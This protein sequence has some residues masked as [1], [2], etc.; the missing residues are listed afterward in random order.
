[1]KNLG[2]S[3]WERA[4]TFRPE[5]SKKDLILYDSK[6]LTTHAVCVGMTGSGKTGLCMALVEEAAI[7]GIP[8]IVID[9]KGD[10]GN[11]MLTF[12][13]LAPE[14]FRPWVDEGEAVRSGMTGDQFARKVSDLWRS[15]LSEWGQG[16]ERIARLRE[17]A[18]FAIYTPG[19]ASGLQIN[20]L[21]SFD[22]PPPHSSPMGMPSR[23]GSRVPWKDFS[24]FWES[25][26]TRFRVGN[27]FFFQTYSPMPG[28]GKRGLDL[29]NSFDPYRNHPSTTWGSSTWSLSLMRPPGSNWPCGSTTCSHPRAFQHGS[30]VNPSA[31]KASFTRRR[32]GPRS[33][34][35]PSPISPTLNECSSSRF[36]SMRSFRGCAANRAPQ[37][38]VP[39]FIWMKSSDIS[40]LRPIPPPNGPC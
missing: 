6:D 22:P 14:D 26:P 3:T 13:T 29:Q 35:S 39:S 7:D 9:P 32:D 21:R 10:L 28:A 1:M 24:P 17:S 16:P 4:T 34:S 31:L 36:S 19:S 38:F 23:I 18:D 30:R 40:R 15:G 5:R 20:I 37:A 25:R 8:V 12:P 2:Y 11:M 33:V 27:T